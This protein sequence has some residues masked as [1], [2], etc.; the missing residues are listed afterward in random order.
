MARALRNLVKWFYLLIAALLIALAVA[1]QSGRSFSHLLGDYNQNIADYL[2]EKL[3]AQVAIG[4]IDARWDGLKPSL[5]VRDLSIRNQS[6]LPIIALERARIRL[7]ILGSL[8]NRR[9]VWSSLVLEDVGL[10][11]AQSEK[12]KWHVSG[13][14]EAR[15]QNAGES[16]VRIGSLVDMLLL[17]NRIEFQSSRLNFAFSN[18]Q[19][20]QLNAPR[21][22][23]ENT[24][25][26]HR[27]SLQV[28]IAKQQ[29]SVYLIMEGQGDPRDKTRFH[30]RGYL[31]LNQFPT[32]EPFAALSS[33]LLQGISPEQ[34]TS[35]GQVNANIW[36]ETSA[37]GKGFEV[38]GDLGLE[39]L[40]LP[41][42]GHQLR[43]DGFKSQL[44]GNWNYDSS[45]TLGLR[46]LGARLKDHGL[47]DLNLAIS[48]KGIQQPLS[49]RMDQ[50]DLARLTA[51]LE[52]SG[53]LGQGKL[54]EVLTT[55]APRGQLSNLLFT[56]PLQSPA[57]WTLKFNF[58]QLAV[59]AWHGV[60]RL[61]NMRGYVDTSMWHGIANLDSGQGFSL[62]FEPTY[63]QPMEFDSARG[64][65]AWHLDPQ[66]N[67]VF[68]NSGVL[69]F[70]KGEENVA[71]YMWVG[72][73][74]KPH[75]ADVELYLLLGGTHLGA[76]LY[77]KYVPVLAPE[78]LRSWLDKSV[79]SHNPGT[80]T[81]AGFVYRASL[82]DK[83]P[84]ARSFDLYL[85]LDNC[86]LDYSEG[87][88]A[89]TDL[90]GKLLVSNADVRASI[91]S[92]R[93]LDS[94]VGR[95]ELQVHPRTQGAG[96]LLQVNGQ[97]QGAALDAMQVLRGGAL[98]QHI[99]SSLDSWT[100]DGSMRA[101]VDLDIPLGS[102]E[103]HPRDMRQQVDVDL[104]V[105]E[106]ALHNL[107]LNG[108]QLSGRISYSST[109][110]LSSEHLQAQLF[111][112]PVEAQ[113]LTRADKAQSL[114]L[115]NLK[116]QA[117]AEDLARWS[118][119]PELEFIKGKLP[120][121][122]RVELR[123]QLAAA[124]APADAAAAFAQQAFAH[125]SVSS[126]MRGASVELPA[127]FGKP[128]AS[129]RQL[130]FDYWLQ[131]KA[132]QIS[133][134]YGDMVQALLR[135]K[136]SSATNQQDSLSNAAI[137]LG[138]QARLSDTP[139]FLVSGYMD[140]FD[141]DA[142]RPIQAKYLGYQAQLTPETRPEPVVD[143]QEVALADMDDPSKLAGLA[144]RAQLTLGHY[145][146]GSV[147]FQN[148]SVAA[149]RARDGWHLGIKNPRISGDLV[150][151]ADEQMPLQ[152]NLDR[153]YLTQKEL[154]EEPDTANPGAER[155]LIN[156]RNLPL[157]NIAVQELYVDQDSYGSWSLQ[158]HPNRKG[159]VIDRIHG[160]IR[161]LTI[162]GAK[163]SLDGAKLIWQQSEEGTQSRFIGGI[164]AGDI[165]QVMRQWDKPDTL[166]SKSAHFTADVYWPGTPEDFSLVDI[167]GN[168][169]LWFEKGR[170]KRDASAGDGILRLMSVLNFDSIARRMRLDFSD[171]YQGGLA[172]DEI[173][174]DVSFNQ[175]DMKFESP[176]VVRGPSSRLQMVGKV[177]LRHEKLQTRLVATLPVAGN[178]TFFAALATGLPA[179]A[180]IY[181]VSKLFKKQVDQ[182]TSISYTI[183]GDWDDPKMAF[184]RLFESEDQL[185]ES[186]DENKSPALKT[187]P[188]KG[189]PKS[190]AP[191]SL[192]NKFSLEN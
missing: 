168:M 53:A 2:S 23:L 39:H 68:I 181:V 176:L 120:Y 98:R 104:L 118:Q 164:S 180:G 129:P 143:S 162:S 151:P 36:F 82:V 112:E 73:P 146:L 49:I 165:A 77:Q 126:D 153:L 56:L 147:R 158:L 149:S 171:L 134:N 6:G 144:F 30:S 137:A 97:V 186:A 28:D 125:V 127:P 5:D 8:M 177:D 156:P 191:H 114:T 10:D 61:R 136:R 72:M 111:N 100:L 157:A 62:Q 159:V 81:Q 3:N 167:S 52:D 175:G 183:S 160:S 122:A 135:L 150:V 148:L 54:H 130:N 117:D 48:S 14:P 115:V 172:Y 90:R 145:D 9:W 66:R 29:R 139:E 69:A 169:S 47:S 38:S 24:P 107:K 128:A 74:W 46:N 141:L 71:G 187:A 60:P 152:V 185:R 59:D 85:D 103:A 96:S 131:D 21:L 121:E 57:D 64:Q 174:G 94:Q 95:T 189:T 88:P 108:R 35:Q 63:A 140:S 79:G 80:A 106:F 170:F 124:D 78:S 15:A 184:D 43:L 34:F 105:P 190:T 173:S 70:T 40:F 188:D 22:L 76:S 93:L 31:Q 178:L 89:L 155:P 192:H 83:N 166:E 163:N 101:R 33:F 1:V 55:L 51:L 133:V 102:G 32:S 12:G 91:A 65:V 116:G 16:S 44:T 45:W 37:D 27:L 119:R 17:S 154:G 75:S 99:G 87:W 7:D 42:A 11:F 50:L 20:L 41:F 142:W 132:A 84:Q 161:G 26:F 19:Q 58:D 25:K 113:I 13:L 86:R 110:G 182:V 4:Q 109:Q 123:H 179:A 18:G 67:Q 138:E 92:A